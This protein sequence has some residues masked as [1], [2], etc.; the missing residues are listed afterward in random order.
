MT[1]QNIFFPFCDSFGL[2]IFL[3]CS[4]CIYIYIYTHLRIFFSYLQFWAI[5]SNIIY[6]YNFQLVS[7][8]FIHFT[9]TLVDF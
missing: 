1:V 8:V 9:A 2:K 3:F 7:L 4:L 5:V 6:L